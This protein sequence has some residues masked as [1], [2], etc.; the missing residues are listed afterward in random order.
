MERNK[1]ES[2]PLKKGDQGGFLRLLTYWEFFSFAAKP[3]PISINSIFSSKIK[4]FQLFMFH[5]I[6]V[7][8]IASRYFMLASP[9]K[10]GF[11]AH[12]RCLGQK[13]HSAK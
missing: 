7:V 2:P 3:L 8:L 10:A 11:T 9:L 12:K 5:K 6:N 4:I 13:R 1:S